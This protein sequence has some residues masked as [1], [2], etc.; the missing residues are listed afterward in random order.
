MHTS[1]A[2]P[3]F[4]FLRSLLAL[5]DVGSS[6]SSSSVFSSSGAAGGGE[7]IERDSPDAR[8]LRAL[9]RGIGEICRAF[10]A[11]LLYTVL[12]GE[13]G[14]IKTGYDAQGERGSFVLS[15]PAGVVRT[16]LSKRSRMLETVPGSRGG[17]H[18]FQDGWPGLDARSCLAMPIH[19]GG[20][21]LG[22]L[23]LLRGPDLPPFGLSD[24]PRAE[25]LA[26]ALAIGEENRRRVA[27][28][29]ELARSDPVTRLCGYRELRAA[30]ERG[31]ARAA[32]LGDPFA[33]L[34]VEI[35][36]LRLYAVREGR[37]VALD[38]FRRI[39]QTIE[40]NIRAGDR[41]GPLGSDAFLI[42]L[43]DT[44]RLGACVVAERVR[45]LAASEGI[46]DPA[47]C[48]LSVTVAVASVPEDGREGSALLR[49]TERAA[50]VGGNILAPP[51]SGEAK[52][53]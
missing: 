6:Y 12:E 4:A 10:S 30:L 29:E 32:A 28:L 37:L 15:R 8:D 1:P 21:M 36:N 17:F 53:G 22:V 2:P 47:A 7:P 23:V 39:G 26:D 13:T 41:I 48:S 9:G 43:P 16:V 34:L 52:A 19:R 44:D 14:W 45:H 35:G 42:L 46:R 27:T 38:I 50:M 20:R 5:A 49:A 40:R 11:H 25:A 33:I 51:L 3:D 24:L 31:A 18:R